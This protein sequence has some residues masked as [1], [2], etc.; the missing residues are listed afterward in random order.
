MPIIPSILNWLT[1]KRLHQI[2]LF[3]KYPF[4]VQQ[5]V[6]LK[7]LDKAKDTEWGKKYDFQ[8]IH[9]TKDYANR[10]P[11]QTYESLSVEIKR[12]LN[13]E[14]NILWPSKIKWFAKSSGTTN[15]KSKFIPVS[16]EA[17]EECH[18]RGGRDI[19]AIYSSLYPD[20]K[21]FKGKGLTLGGSH[22]INGHNNESHYGDLSAILI[23][24]LPF[25]MD[26]IKT[27]NQEIALMDQWEQK[28]KKLADATMHENVTSLAGVPSWMLV[29][30]KYILA[31]TGKRTLLEIWPNLELFLH[32]GVSFVPYQEQYRKLIPSKEMHY[33]ETY[34][35]SEGFFAIQDEPS[36][37]DMLL[38]LDIGVY[39]EFVPM[40]EI[41][42]DFPRSVSIGE[43][44]KNKN[45]AVVISTNSGLW[46]YMIGDTIKFTSLCPHKIKVSGRTKHFLNVFGEEVIVDNADKALKI[47]CERTGAV[48]SEYTAG[49]VFMNTERKGTHEWL[50]EFEK[51]PSDFE[52]FGKL[53]DEALMSINSDYEAKRY[54]DITLERPLIR[55]LKRGTF[56]HWLQDKNKLGGQNKVPRLSND[57]KYLEEL[58]AIEDR[59]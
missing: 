57:R 26:F 25:W 8:S 2:E 7:L 44:E 37:D 43:V 40:E 59:E 41:C 12:L 55:N 34:N 45:Y 9:N 5:E 35:A 31:Q 21:L 18:Y 1:I 20:T 47:A 30:I 53:L 11:V 23:Q 24:N 28:L 32:G 3:K 58:Y 29:L 15:D 52:S 42:K 10:I 22:Q 38:M 49:P 16:F 14:Q 51:E 27:P 48:I 36:K 17:L 39:Y 54:K 4:D 19:M 50:I 46:R 6:L 33:L 56:Y 13:G